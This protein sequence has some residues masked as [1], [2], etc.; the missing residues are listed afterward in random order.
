MPM[1]MHGACT[2][3]LRAQAPRGRDATRLDHAAFGRLR[4]NAENVID[5]NKLERAL[6]EK[7]ASTFSRR[8]LGRNVAVAGSCHSL[9]LAI[10]LLCA[11]A[12]LCAA[13]SAG[14]QSLGETVGEAAEALHL[15]PTAP[16][17]AGFV[18]QARPDQLDYQRLG[19]TDKANHKKSA[20]ELDALAS[21]LENARA[22][23]RRAAQRVRAPDPP[24][25]AKTAK[26]KLVQENR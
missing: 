7:A 2:V 8:A 25:E 3:A 9:S 1:T 11:I 26:A 13:T 21:S 16:P 4:P 23:N 5:P 22:A 6:R 18:E 17:A 10:A 15:A 14:A 24:T 12:P 19:P 20:A